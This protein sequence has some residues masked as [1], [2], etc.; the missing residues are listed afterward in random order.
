MIRAVD[1]GSVFALARY[2]AE[3]AKPVT[4]QIPGGSLD[5]DVRIDDKWYSVPWS[6]TIS[7]HR[8]LNAKNNVKGLAPM[9]I[10]ESHLVTTAD[11]DATIQELRGIVESQSWTLDDSEK[12]A[13]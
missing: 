13:A 1:M 5:I 4:D 11:V 12:S 2:A 7:V 6:V 9:V 3:K 10:Q 8:A